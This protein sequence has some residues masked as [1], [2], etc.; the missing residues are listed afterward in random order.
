ME[1]STIKYEIPEPGIG[2]ITLDRPERLNAI[3]LD[4][5]EELHVLC[6]QLSSDENVRVVIITGQGRGFC[7]GADLTDE[8]VSKNAANLFSNS[9]TFLMKL[10][11]V[12]SRLIVD[13][14]HIPQPIIAAVNGAAAGGGLCI[15]L[16]SDVI[17]ASLQAAFT[18]SFINIGLSGGELGTTYFLPKAVGNARAAEILLTGRTVGATEADKIGL[19]SRLVDEDKL[20]ETAME[21]ASSMLEK[22]PLGL[23]FTKEA[24]NQNLTAPSLEAAIELENRNQSILC[25]TPEFFKAV[26]NFS[27][28]QKE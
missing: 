21:I 23:R 8:R 10:Q 19:I 1:Y 14:R 18:P 17:I 28:R 2:L 7:S 24:L 6:E 25:I 3:N 5:L 27:K 20:M 4:M 9:A 16:A 15:A 12:Y 13:M 26:D 11:K 22:S